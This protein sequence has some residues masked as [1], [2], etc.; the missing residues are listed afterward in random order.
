MKPW[1]HVQVY[2]QVS[3]GLPAEGRAKQKPPLRQGRPSQGS[4]RGVAWVGVGS[5]GAGVSGASWNGEGTAPMLLLLLL[6]SIRRRSRGGAKLR[7]VC[8][9]QQQGTAG[10]LQTL[11]FLF[12]ILFFSFFVVWEFL[13]F[14]QSCCWC[15]LGS[16]ATERCVSD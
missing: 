14:P 7:T 15:W 9:G 11:I 8:V 2:S 5:A 13:L 1:L 4:G 3:S 10:T 12:Y 16:A 6:S